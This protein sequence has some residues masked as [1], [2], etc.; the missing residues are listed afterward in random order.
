MAFNFLCPIC[1]TGVFTPGTSPVSEVVC[2]KCGTE[3]SVTI[4]DNVG[5]PLPVGEGARTISDSSEASCYNHFTKMA[6]CGCDNCGKLM[7]TV[8]NIDV[9]NKHFCPDCVLNPVVARTFPQL[10]NERLCEEKSVWLTAWLGAYPL[11]VCLSIPL[12]IGLS[13]VF[14]SRPGSLIGNSRS[15]ML[16][17]VLLS[18]FSPIIFIAFC[19]G[20]GVLVA[21]LI[22]AAAPAT[23]T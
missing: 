20:I 2:T 1:Q 3:L 13:I 18:I 19:L 17:G 16:G 22:A 9:E 12:T 14:W 5:R 4:F 8:C 11:F 7:C 6:V 15:W 10:V 23:H 21:V